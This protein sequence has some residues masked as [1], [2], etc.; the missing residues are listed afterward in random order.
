MVPLLLICLI[1]SS[2]CIWHSSWASKLNIVKI[3]LRMRCEEACHWFKLSWIIWASSLD[4]VK[5]KGAHGNNLVQELIINVKFNKV[6]HDVFTSDTRFN[7]RYT[8]VSLQ[9]IYVVIQ[10]VFIQVD[11]VQQWWFHK[12]SSTLSFQFKSRKLPSSRR[13]QD[14]S[15]L[16]NTLT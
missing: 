9:V 2:G 7:K 11:L 4:Q 3:T 10:V 14:S 13:A 15:R 16:T 6:V 5:E 12:W 8:I 1:W